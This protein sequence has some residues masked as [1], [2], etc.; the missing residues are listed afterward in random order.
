MKSL[1]YIEYK[2]FAYKIYY[3]YMNPELH[4]LILYFLS[5]NSLI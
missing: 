1:P 5:K 4:W 3:F 2:I